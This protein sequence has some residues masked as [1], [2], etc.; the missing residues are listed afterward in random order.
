VA[1][2]QALPVGPEHERHVGVGDGTQPEAARHVQLARRGVDEVRAADDLA[3][4]LGVVVDAD[5]EVVGGGAVVAPYDE[6]VDHVLARAQH[7]IG[8]RDP[9]GARIQPQRRRAPA[10]LAL[11]D[12]RDGQVPAGA[13]IGA[14]GQRAVGSRGGL[15]DLRA[16]APAAVQRALALQPGDR[17]VVELAALGL[18]HDGL[19]GPQAQRGEVLELPGLVLGARP[20]GVEVLDADEEPPAARAGQQVREQRRAQVAEVQPA[21][22][23][24]REAP[25]VRVA[26]RVRSDPETIGPGWA[27]STLRRR[28]E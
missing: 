4:P 17:L 18:A 24:R 5:R 16:G 10:A 13:R 15:A 7:A 28:V 20:G 21:G 14:L 22:R 27:A 1:L 9:R 11:G 2:G 25:V 23:G 19:V 26:V 6:V 3:D 8:E 12:L